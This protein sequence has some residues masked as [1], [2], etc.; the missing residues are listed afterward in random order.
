MLGAV[1]A[2]VV[3]WIAGFDE[4]ALAGE[5]ALCLLGLSDLAAA[6]HLYRDAT[7]VAGFLGQ[8]AALPATARKEPVWPV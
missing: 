2:E 1:D 5:A 4:G 7:E 8:L 6:L 3:E